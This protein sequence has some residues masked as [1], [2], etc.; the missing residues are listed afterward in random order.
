MFVP[1]NRWEG[2]TVERHLVIRVHATLMRYSSLR[3]RTCVS[4]STRTRTRS[5]NFLAKI[6]VHRSSHVGREVLHRILNLAAS[7]ASWPPDA[8]E[9]FCYELKRLNS[10]HNRA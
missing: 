9:F 2:R 5:V 1:V 3:S 10:K 6:P 4:T 7:S 8:R